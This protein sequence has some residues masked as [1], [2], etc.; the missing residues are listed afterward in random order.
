MRRTRRLPHKPYVLPVLGSDNE[1]DTCSWMPQRDVRLMYVHLQERRIARW[2][3]LV[4]AYEANPEIWQSA[5]QYVD[6]HPIYWHLRDPQGPEHERNLVH[7]YAANRY[8]VEMTVNPV[9]P[10]SH[11]VSGVEERNTVCEVWAES[12][13]RYWRTPEDWAAGTSHDWELDCGGATFEQAYV[14]LARKIWEK[15]GNDRS[16]AH[17]DRQDP[18]PGGAGGGGIH[19]VVPVDPQWFGPDV[20]QLRP[21]G[22]RGGGLVGGNEGT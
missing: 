12:G 18:A 8:D 1:K 3:K 2:E 16:K 14:N 20:A 22:V 6:E 7:T 11:H 19:D 5:W 9:Q 13:P 21:G 17:E 10:R 4:R 15:Y